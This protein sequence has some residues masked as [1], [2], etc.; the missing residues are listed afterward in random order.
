MPT[1]EISFRSEVSPATIST[2]LL[3]RPRVS[4]RNLMSASLAAPSTGGAATFIL[5]V[6]SSITPATAVFLA[7]GITLTLMAAPRRASLNFG[8]RIVPP[9]AR[10][11]NALRERAGDEGND[12]PAGDLVGKQ[13]HHRRQVEHA[14]RRDEITERAHQRFGQIG[15]EAARRVPRVQRRE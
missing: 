5:M 3:G 6:P 11:T 14:H 1:S 8:L 13:R 9:V 10:P 4:A 2:W 7:R 12:Q 15:E